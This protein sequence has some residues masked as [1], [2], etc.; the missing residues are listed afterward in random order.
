MSGVSFFS[1]WHFHH[2]FF[3][4]HRFWEKSSRDLYVL[5]GPRATNASQRNTREFFHPAKLHLLHFPSTIYFL[6]HCGLIPIPIPPKPKP[7]A[8]GRSTRQSLAV[9]RWR[10]GTVAMPQLIRPHMKS[11]SGCVSCKQR[12][13]KVR[14]RVSLCLLRWTLSSSFVSPPFISF[15]T[16]CRACSN[17]R[18]PSH[19]P[20]PIS[21]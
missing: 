20:S 21:P 19:H 6:L 4:L 14:G 15:S 16:L 2:F 18:H 12:R 8:P 5:N 10:D 1:L 11:R 3:F 17:S 7:P 9:A 13:V